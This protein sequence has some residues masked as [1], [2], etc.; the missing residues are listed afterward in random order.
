MSSYRPLQS[1][2]ILGRIN[3]PPLVN[4]QSFDIR[5]SFDFR[6]STLDTSRAA[7]S[8]VFLAFLVVLT[9]RPAAAQQRPLVTEDAEP[10]GAGH[11]LIEGGLDFDHDQQYPVS[12]LKGDL[13][14]V[15]T[16]GASLGIGSIAEVQIKSGLYDHLTISSQNVAP[17]SGI[18]TVSGTSAQGLDDTVIAT[19][20]RLV[21][22]TEGRPAIGVRFATK[23]PTASTEGG[24]GLGTT[25]FY[26]SFLG[27]KTVQ[28][29]RLVGNIGFGILGDPTSG[30]RQNDV[31]TYGFSFARALTDHAEMVGEVNGR[32][33]TR[34]NAAP[35]GTESRGIVKL[36]GRYTHGPLR[37]DAA[38]LLG[39]TSLD[40][41]IGFTTGFTYVFNAFTTP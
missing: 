10:I 14:R 9:C 20:I 32:L 28:S 30:D 23:L 3:L 5:H 24:L 25:D 1:G 26:M 34:A 41:T 39:L 13:V 4:R 40:P 37:V 35:P 21:P 36:G 8:L 29:I 22:E 33:S 7:V 12:G 38:I 18:L 27:A 17:F 16:I 6:H 19:K 31:L 11:L 15:A 2:A